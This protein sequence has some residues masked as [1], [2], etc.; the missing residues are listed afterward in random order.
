[1]VLAVLPRDR[2]V[3]LCKVC[4]QQKP[5]H[6]SGITATLVRDSYTV[7]SSLYCTNKQ[8]YHHHHFLASNTKQLPSKEHT[9]NPPTCK[10][11]ATA[12]E[13]KAQ[14]PPFAIFIQGFTN[15]YALAR[16]RIFV[17]ALLHPAKPWKKRTHKTDPVPK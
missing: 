8:I 13:Q 15:K 3:S 4:S 14:S 1:M 6:L 5:T 10:P 7:S 16:T 11:A 17:P 12:R 9:R 2:T